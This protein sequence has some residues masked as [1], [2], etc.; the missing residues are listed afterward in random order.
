MCVHKIDQQE[1]YE[2]VSIFAKNCFYYDPH[3]KKQV[4]VEDLEKCSNEIDT[5]HHDEIASCANKILRSSEP[6]K[7]DLIQDTMGKIE[8]FHSDI[9]P[10]II[11]NGN[12]LRGELTEK[13]I[14]ED[15]C[16]SMGKS[17]SIKTCEGIMEKKDNLGRNMLPNVRWIDPQFSLKFYAKIF[18]TLSGAAVI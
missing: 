16:E 5:K 11:I 12:I 18:F 1:W 15:I 9:L 7:D 10:S 14:L 6:L 2:Y 4:L 8:A 3:I 17:D 13:N